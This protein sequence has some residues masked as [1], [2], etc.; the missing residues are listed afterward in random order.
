[1]TALAQQAIDGI[2]TN[3]VAVIEG[4]G[5]NTGIPGVYSNDPLLIGGSPSNLTFNCTGGT[6]KNTIAYSSGSYASDRWTA[7]RAPS[8][9]L[10]C[11]SATNSANVSA[12]RKISAWSQGSKAFTTANFPA[13]ITTGD[14]F[15]ILEGFRSVADDVEADAVLDRRYSTWVEPGEPIDCYGGGNRIVTGTLALDLTIKS[16]GRMTNARKSAYANGEILRT[17]ILD[18]DNW[19]STYTRAL[20]PEGSSVELDES[21]KTRIVVQIRLPI[22]YRY[23]MT[24]E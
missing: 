20:L 8:F 3:T 23:A 4:T 7:T 6:A 11:T 5:S 22:R 19:E 15:Y 24:M 14:T 16:S 9:W 21:E 17:A 10:L 1:V 12:A 13:N 18:R 2:I